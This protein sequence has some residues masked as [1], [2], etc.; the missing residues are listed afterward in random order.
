MQEKLVQTLRNPANLIKIIPIFSFSISLLMLYFIYP[1][2]YE[3]TWK[4][5]T[6][7]LFFLWLIFLK[8]LLN[9][10][11]I[12]VKIQKLKSIRFVSL[13]IL[14]LMPVV[15]VFV[16]NFAGLNMV[17]VEVSP[18]HYYPGA[19]P[20]YWARLMPLSVEYLVF[21]LLFAL[22]ILTAY[23]KGSL[24]IFSL[25]LSFIIIIGSIY[26]IDNLYPFGEFAPFQI[27]V[28]T[29]TVLAAKFLSFMGYQT[30]IAGE[31][32]GTPR[33]IVWNEKGIASYGIAW[34][35]S[36][37]DSL[38]LYSV[39]TILF[40]NNSFI[41]RK[42]GIIYFL[43][44]AIVTYLINILRIATIFIIAINHGTYSPEVQRFHDY[45]G[46]LYSITWIVSYPLLIIMAHSIWSKLKRKSPEDSA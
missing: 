22:M 17:I 44:G 4:G 9:W 28:P 5:R 21:A 10:E 25:P 42:R 39:V 16:A 32:Y 18:K 1:E 2:S 37:V 46:P 41:S 40:L 33:L 3:A 12:Q 30:R 20:Y 8:L 15:Y 45:Y 6:Y 36:G 29:T 14:I 24:G 27:I 35:C 13:L 23:G 43:I 31:V 7:Y 26:M 11:K 34:P 19:D 38:L